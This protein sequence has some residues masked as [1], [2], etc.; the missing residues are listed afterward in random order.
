MAFSYGQFQQLQLTKF[1]L[2]A[3]QEEQALGLERVASQQS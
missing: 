3:H 2:Q 1:K